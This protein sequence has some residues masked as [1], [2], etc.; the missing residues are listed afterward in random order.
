MGHS[1]LMKIAYFN[2]RCERG[3]VF[4]CI[5]RASIQYHQSYGYMRA[6]SGRETGYTW[7]PC[8]KNPKSTAT[9]LFQFLNTT[10]WGNWNR[11]R[12]YPICDPKWNSLAA[13]L[14][15]HL[16]HYSWWQ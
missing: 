3:D 6:I 4:A 1:R 9:G 10:W 5:H 7:K 2:H 13:G 16:G 14:A 12:N 8:L 11:Y 15:M